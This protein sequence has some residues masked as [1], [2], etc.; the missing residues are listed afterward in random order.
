MIT[1]RSCAT[2]RTE[3]AR[4]AQ[5][6][7]APIVLAAGALYLGLGARDLRDLLAVG[8]SLI[9]V[10][11]LRG[12]SLV[13]LARTIADALRRTGSHAALATAVDR[14][15]TIDEESWGAWQERLEGTI[16]E[17]ETGDGPR[18]RSENGSVDSGTATQTG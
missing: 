11:E 17:P 13:G 15:M 14:I 9:D 12:R 5:G 2:A 4:P 7:L 6:G 8:F 3:A 18:A 10:A 1:E 16:A